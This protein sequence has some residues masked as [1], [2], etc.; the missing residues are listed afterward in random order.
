MGWS[1]NIPSYSIEQL[2]NSVEALVRGKKPLLNTLQPHYS[3]FLGAIKRKKQ[4]SFV[5]EGVAVRSS[6]T[7]VEIKE[8]P[9]GVWTAKYK[10]HLCALA[11]EKFITGFT[12]HHTTDNVLF[13]IH[14]TKEMLDAIESAGILSYLKLS[15]N[16]NLSNM[17]A[18]DQDGNIKKYTSPD[19]IIADHF[20]A[21]LVAY[22]RRKLLMIHEAMESEA[23]FRNQARFIDDIIAGSILLFGEKNSQQTS[24][25]SSDNMNMKLKSM[26]YQTK[27]EIKSLHLADKRIEKV[28]NSP[29]SLS[30]GFKYLMDMPIQSLVTENAKKLKASAKNASE[31]LKAIQ[32][33]TEQEIWL[34]DLAK[35]KSELRRLGYIK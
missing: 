14:G 28:L 10:E 7:S 20:K 19:E 16:I 32:L 21:R 31:K 27:D 18:F 9:I 30:D 8:L 17:H 1:T 24:S 25:A 6:G 13:K 11:K 26:G 2:I 33:L 3:G 15:S 34:Q 35:L 5:S 23:I 4:D 12:E 29:E 22:S